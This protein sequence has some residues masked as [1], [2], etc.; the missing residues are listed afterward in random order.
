MVG[1]RFRPTWRH[2]SVSVVVLLVA[3]AVG[4]AWMSRAPTA[5]Q[6]KWTSAVKAAM[7]EQAADLRKVRELTSIYPWLAPILDALEAARVADRQ[8]EAIPVAIVVMQDEIAALDTT[9]AS[10]TAPVRTFVFAWNTESEAVTSRVAALRKIP[11]GIVVEHWTTD[12]GV[13]GSINNGVRTSS[14]KTMRSGLDVADDWYL[15]VRPGTQFDNGSLRSFIQLAQSA[16]LDAGIIYG[17]EHSAFAFTRTAVDTVGYFDEVFWPQFGE[18]LDYRWRVGIAGLK[19]V[20]TGPTVSVDSSRRRNFTEAYQRQLTRSGY[21][22]DYARLK[23]GDFDLS[24]V[25]Q[26]RPPSGYTT[27]FNLLNAPLTLWSVDAAHRMCIRHSAVGPRYPKPI[28]RDHERGCWYNASI[29][30]ALLRDS[31]NVP[32]RLQYPP[33]VSSFRSDSDE[34]TYFG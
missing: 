7:T 8:T 23:W 30:L 24:Q 2:Y 31:T 22:I 27:P 10:L 29:L 21:G 15:V 34:L 19:V 6:S 1:P 17:A 26:P 32:Q 5:A 13:S 33:L 3:V 12:R 28:V 4:M 20:V 14:I 25:E 11:H 18:A 9:L 16:R